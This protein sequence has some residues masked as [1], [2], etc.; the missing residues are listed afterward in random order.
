MKSI[1]AQTRSATPK[2]CFEGSSCSAASKV[3]AVHPVL[4]RRG[5]EFMVFEV[6]VSEGVFR[7][8]EKNIAN[9]HGCG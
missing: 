5:D 1:D 9:S 7:G 8:E 3:K 2:A 6:Q 4:K